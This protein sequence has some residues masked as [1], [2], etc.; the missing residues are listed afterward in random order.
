MNLLYDID[1]DIDYR[2]AE[3]C[4]P[5][6]AIQMQHETDKTMIEQLDQVPTTSI[7]D[8]FSNLTAKK[9]LQLKLKLEIRLN[10][11]IYNK[12]NKLH[13]RY[14]EGE[15]RMIIILSIN[16]ILF[17]NIFEYGKVKN[18]TYIDCFSKKARIIIVNQKSADNII[19]ALD[20]A[21]QYLGNS[22]ILWSDNEKKFTNKLVQ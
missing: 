10:E 3:K 21:F 5:E 16:H 17:C 7:I 20:Y 4:D 18:F 15:R 19:K 1:H 9:L 11:E 14:N 6:I 22:K 12:V 2:D 13:H 8:K